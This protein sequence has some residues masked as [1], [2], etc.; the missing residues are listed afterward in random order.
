MDWG[1][2]VMGSGDEES[3]IGDKLAEEALAGVGEATAERAGLITGAGTMHGTAFAET[4]G[5]SAIPSMAAEGGTYSE[6]AGSETGNTG[7]SLPKLQFWY[8]DMLSN[9]LLTRFPLVFLPCFS[10]RERVLPTTRN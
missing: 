10:S 4:A 5:H 3:K 9:T 6:H 2:V 8:D 1:G 7:S